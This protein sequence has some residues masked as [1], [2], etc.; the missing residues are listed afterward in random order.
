G[1]EAGGESEKTDS[2]DDSDSAGVAAVGLGNFELHGDSDARDFRPRDGEDADHSDGS[3]ASRDLRGGAGE[4]AVAYG[5]A[6]FASSTGALVCT[7]LI[8]MVKRPLGRDRVQR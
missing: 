8:W 4:F 7:S 3:P 5:F 2:R 6:N 1:F